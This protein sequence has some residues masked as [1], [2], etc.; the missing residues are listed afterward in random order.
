LT[1]YE[2]K[3]KQSKRTPYEVQ[4]KSLNLMQ[5]IYNYTL[6]YKHICILAQVAFV[7]V[8]VLTRWRTA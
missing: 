6:S 7:S 8:L 5:K 1:Y 3:E 2:S 4:I